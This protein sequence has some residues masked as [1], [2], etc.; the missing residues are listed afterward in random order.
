M[1]RLFLVEPVVGLYAFSAFLIYP[2]VQQYVYRRLW[3]E[4]TN[5]T[6]PAS[7]NTSRCTPNNHTNHSSYHEEVQRQASLFSL[8]TDLF[9]T[10]PSLVVTVMLVAYSDRGGRK[11]TILMPLIGTLIYTSSFLTISYFELNVYLLIGASLLSSLFGGLGTFL[12][13]C[14]AYIADLCESDRE[15]TLRMAGLDMIIGLLAGLASLSTG[16]FLRAAGFNWPLLTSALCQCLVLLYVIFILEETVKKAPPD[17]IILD[18][19][20]QGSALKQM[21]YGVYHL[22]ER[23]SSKSRTVLVLLILIFITFAFAEFGGLSMVTLY[24]LNEPLCW[25]E[26]LIGYGSALSTIAFLTSFLGLSA[27]MYCGMPQLVIILVGILSCVSGMVLI[28]F[29]NTTLLM[30]LA[31]IPMLFTIMPFPVLRSMMSKI[32]SKS[33]QGA[34]FACVSCLD[35]LTSSVAVAVFNSVYAATVSWF[36]GFVFLLGAGLFAIPLTFLGV[37]GVIGLDV[38]TE[39]EESEPPDSGEEKLVEDQN[40]NRSLLS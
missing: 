20:P 11:I 40:D 32:V 5:T 39:V 37:L 4:L 6:Y 7:D 1:K 21:F 31:R 15:K 22:F 27:F 10:I 30:F 9:S 13:G 33:E 3:Q 34:L 17:A 29:A 35:S 14:F 38:S 28:A 36:P 25:S 23:A 24:E 18:G 12:G 8:Y 19:A 2:L 26:I 16:Y